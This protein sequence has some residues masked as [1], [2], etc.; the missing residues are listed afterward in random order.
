MWKRL[1]GIA[2]LALA[3]AALAAPN[4]ALAGGQ[5]KHQPGKIIWGE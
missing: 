3:A 2:V 5:P 1:S 4:A